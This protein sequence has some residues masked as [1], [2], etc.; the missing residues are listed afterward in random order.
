MAQLQHKKK[1]HFI[2]LYDDE[3]VAARAYNAKAK[4]LMGDRAKLN[5]V[6]GEYIV[7]NEVSDG[8]G[9]RKR[10]NTISRFKGVSR[11][12]HTTWTVE[13]RWKGKRYK[14]GNFASEVEA[15]KRY[16]ELALQVTANDE[17]K[18]RLNVIPDDE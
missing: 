3:V 12:S 14:G 10:Q 17:E 5:D 13:F 18:P 7:E 6:G 4:E 16:N 9:Q 8:I 11:A 15:G 2:G 1:P